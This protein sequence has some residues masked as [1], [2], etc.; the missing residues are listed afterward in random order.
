MPCL[1]RLLLLLVPLLLLGCGGG[2]SSDAAVDLRNP[3]EGLSFPDGGGAPTPDGYKIA[4]RLPPSEA[5]V[6]GEWHAAV[7]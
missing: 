1:K 4:D 2:G 6:V 7:H 5:I 3:A